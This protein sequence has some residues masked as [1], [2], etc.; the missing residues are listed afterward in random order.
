MVSTILTPNL[1]SHNM[2]GGNSS[3]PILDISVMDARGAKKTFSLEGGSALVTFTLKINSS[4]PAADYD[5]S[6]LDSET[7]ELRTNGCT[8]ISPAAPAA[9][10]GLIT[11]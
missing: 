6:Y 1:L 2:S 8:L 10:N 11:C 5:C 9:E 7:N 3:N 4:A